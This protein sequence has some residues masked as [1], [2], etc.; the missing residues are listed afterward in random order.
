ML[1]YWERG[2]GLKVI[3]HTLTSVPGLPLQQPELLRFGH[4]LEPSSASE[5]KD[6]GSTSC[7][8]TAGRST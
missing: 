3:A 1:I 7:S 6:R 8:S 5:L 2:R 4:W